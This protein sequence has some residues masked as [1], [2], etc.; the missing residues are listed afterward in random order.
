MRTI[1]VITLLSFLV[2]QSPLINPAKAPL[3][4]AGVWLVLILVALFNDTK[5]RGF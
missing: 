1:I 5:R 2:S 3:V 4:F